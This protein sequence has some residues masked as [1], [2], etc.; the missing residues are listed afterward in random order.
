MTRRD[1]RRRR[2]VTYCG[3]TPF[4]AGVLIWKRLQPPIADAAGVCHTTSC[5]AF[6]AFISLLLVALILGQWRQ[7][8][9]IGDIKGRLTALERQVSELDQRVTRLEQTVMTLVGE[10]GEIRGRL[11]LM[12]RHRHEPETGRVILTPEEVSAD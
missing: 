11:D 10:V 6:S 9:D 2:P 5:S 8:G 3:G 1:C 12:L 4:I 7:S